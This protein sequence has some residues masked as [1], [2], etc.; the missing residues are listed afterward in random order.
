MD[1]NLIV[2]KISSQFPGSILESRRFGRTGAISFWVEAKAIDQVSQF[3]KA[4]PQFSLDWLE[5]LSVVEFE[6]ALVVS[7]FLRSSSEAHAEVILR[8]SLVPASPEAE[9]EIPSV[10]AI[11][12]MGIPMEQEAYEMFG[13]RFIQGVFQTSEVDSSS[14]AGHQPSCLLPE[15][16]RKFPLRKKLKS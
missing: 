4:D 15:Q 11:W 9:V 6:E 8:V 3:L 16:V 7:Y 5:S 13:V 10:R 2:S 1:K 12:P 14:F